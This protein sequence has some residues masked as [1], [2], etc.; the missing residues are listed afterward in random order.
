MNYFNGK[1][2]VLTGTFSVARRHVVGSLKAAGANVQPN[3]TRATQIVIVGER[4]G[5]KLDKARNMGLTLYTE[6]KMRE[7]LDVKAPDPKPT[8]RGTTAALPEHYGEF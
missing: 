5:S 2:V 8:A 7:M 3:V 6:E 1:N 4:A